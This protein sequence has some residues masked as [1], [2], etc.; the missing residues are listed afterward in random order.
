MK[1]RDNGSA[2]GSGWVAGI[3][4]MAG[5]SS[6]LA[7]RK[8]LLT[9]GEQPLASVVLARALESDLSKVILVLGHGAKEIKKTLGTAKGHSKLIIMNNPDYRKGLSSSIKVGLSKI[10][11]RVSGVMFLMGDQP[12]LTTEAIN[13]LIKVFLS[14]PAPIVLP[15]YG[16]RPG[17]PVIFRTSLIPE[18]RKVTGDTGGRELVRKYWNLVQTVPIRPQRTGWDM[19][20]WEDY[21]KLKGFF[22]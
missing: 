7:F 4:L 6:R 16:K 5:L 13:K 18:L 9:L 12:L 10:D 8:A 15:L 19:D 2:N 3:L 14:S 20:T 17:N 22:K 21:Q 11:P 1:K